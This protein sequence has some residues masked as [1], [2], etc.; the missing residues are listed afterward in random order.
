MGCLPRTSYGNVADG[1]DGNIKAT[2]FEEPQFK[3]LVPDAYH[4]SVQHTE[5]CQPFP[6]FDEIT[7]HIYD[8]Q[9]YNFQFIFLI[10]L[11]L[12]FSFGS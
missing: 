4:H 7:F 11:F 6:Y 10:F 1:D 5:W 12:P 9:I 2:G 3:Q 8:L